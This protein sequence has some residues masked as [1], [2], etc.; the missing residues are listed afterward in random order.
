MSELR[1]TMSSCFGVVRT[2]EGMLDGLATIRALESRNT[3]QRF[4]N[5]LNTAKLIAVSALRR[6]ESRGGHYRSDF[7][8]EDP[9]LAKRSF[10]TLAQAETLADAYLA[11]RR[12]GAA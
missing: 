7:P 3:I 6:E 4:E 1:R 2:R 10:I 9:A 8:A 11:E 12:A 5:V